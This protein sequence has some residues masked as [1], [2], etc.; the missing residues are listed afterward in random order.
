M[1]LDIFS[2]EESEVRYYCRKLPKLL[3]SAS[4]SIVR[5]IEGQRFID[6]MSACGALNYGHNHPVLKRAALEYLAGDG[7]VAGLDFHTS[8]KLAFVELFARKYSILAG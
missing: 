1:Y 3:V 7:I 5:D 2:R 6:F 8:A 4:G